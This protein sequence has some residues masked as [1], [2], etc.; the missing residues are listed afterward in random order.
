MPPSLSF[1][2][3]MKSQWREE[4][5]E[6]FKSKNTCISEA[7]QHCPWQVLIRPVHKSLRSRVFNYHHDEKA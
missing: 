2:G 4:L 1:M 6:A 5:E 7:G 3:T